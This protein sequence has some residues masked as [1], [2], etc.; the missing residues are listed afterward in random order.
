[1]SSKLPYFRWHPKDF[2]TDENVRLMSM[3]EVGLYVLCLNH[4]W[5]NGS[6]PD[7]LRKIA[8]IVGQPFP[9]VKKSWPAVSKCFMKNEDGTL[10]NSRLEEERKLAKNKGLSYSGNSKKRWDEPCNGI[11]RG[12]DS[13]S[14]SDSSSDSLTTNSE[15]ASTRTRGDLVDFSTFMHRWRQHRGFKKPQKHLCERAEQRWQSIEIDENELAAALDGYFDSEWAKKENYPILGFVKDPHSWIMDVVPDAE[16]SAPERDYVADWNR[17]VPAAPIAW[18]PAHSPI[19]DLRSCVLD[20]MFRD[21]FD[22]VCQTVQRIYEV[23]N[24]DVSWINFP[25]L[26]RKNNGKGYGWFRILTEFRGMAVKP[27]S[28]VEQSMEDLKIDD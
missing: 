9:Q 24:G 19:T 14:V 11:P 21:R 3:C 12:S 17:L 23:K 28:K 4:A 10:T 18:D 16:P 6:L 22:E 20:P 5:V 1:V 26:I 27:K 15:N 2:D 8:K 13:E 25:W 7:D